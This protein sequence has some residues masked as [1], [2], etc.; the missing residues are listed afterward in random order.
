[1]EI[2]VAVVFAVVAAAAAAFDVHPPPPQK[3]QLVHPQKLHTRLCRYSYRYSSS[4]SPLALSVRT[5]RVDLDNDIH[6]YD[7]E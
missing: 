2:A 7:D 1:M 6:M 5:V 3:K 4:D